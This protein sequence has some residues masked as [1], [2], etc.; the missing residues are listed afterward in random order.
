MALFAFWGLFA[1]CVQNVSKIFGLDACDGIAEILFGHDVVPVEHGS[2]T[3]TR[4]THHNELWNAEPAR[5]RDEASAQIVEPDSI[6]SS[7][8]TRSAESLPHVLPDFSCARV[9]EQRSARQSARERLQDGA[10][11]LREHHQAG[12]FA[13]GTPK[14][15]SGDAGVRNSPTPSPNRGRWALPGCKGPAVQVDCL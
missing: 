9:T 6:E 5:T 12:F 15:S 2:G 7:G 4:H 14:E 8:F 1:N 13:L 3:V 10:D 11:A